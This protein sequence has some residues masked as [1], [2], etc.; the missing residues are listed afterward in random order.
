MHNGQSKRLL[1]IYVPD[2]IT[3]SFILTIP[4]HPQALKQPLNEDLLLTEEQKL[5]INSKQVRQ[6]YHT[7]D[8]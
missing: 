8:V 2:F 1:Q 6:D 5:F 4:N 7:K 3:K